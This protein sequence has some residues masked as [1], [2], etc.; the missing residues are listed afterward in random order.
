MSFNAKASADVGQPRW[1]TAIAMFLAGAVAFGLWQKHAAEQRL[2]TFI[3]RCPN[4]STTNPIAMRTPDGR[5]LIVSLM[6]VPE[7]YVSSFCPEPNEI[8]KSLGVLREYT[9]AK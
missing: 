4:L 7:E 3:R 6:D 9:E 1:L 5:V 8:S 2:S